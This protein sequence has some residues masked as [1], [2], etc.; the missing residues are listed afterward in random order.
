VRKYAY[1]QFATVAGQAATT[2]G[3]PL[4][5]A[6]YN[7]HLQVRD[8]PGHPWKDRTPLIAANL[9]SAQPTIAAVEEFVPAMWTNGDGGIGLQAALRNQGLGRYQLTRD[10]I[11]SPGVPG[12]TR[13]L[14]DPTRVQ[15]VSSC[16]PGQISCAIRLPDAHT[17][18]TPYAL[19]RDLATGSEFWF[20]AAHLTPGNNAQTDALRGQQV[21]AIVD[22]MARMN[23]AGLP[24]IAGGDLNGA[25]TSAGQDSPHNAFLGAGY[26]DTSAAA[27]QVHLNYNTVNA[28]K[29][30]ER[31]SAYGFGARYD[32]IF[33]LGM[34][35]ADR[36]E[37]VVTGAPFPSDHNL[38]FTDL[39]LP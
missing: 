22:A 28:Y 23:T 9:A 7:I 32:S 31:P 16:D 35:G 29:S 21:Q 18:Y 26:Y 37:Q 8:I 13:I 38:V 10:T 20:V 6:N 11:Y 33:T 36:F 12:D 27:V 4:R 25:Q 34:P 39:R 2:T 5:V 15:M 3:S 17:H 19:F 14:Y 30:P 24:V 1:I